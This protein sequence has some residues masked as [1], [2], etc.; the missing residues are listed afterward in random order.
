MHG[1]EKV[2][3]VLLTAKQG[4]LFIQHL[5]LVLYYVWYKLL[6]LIVPITQPILFHKRKRSKR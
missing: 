4:Q 1:E 2:C 3:S 6:G 5:V